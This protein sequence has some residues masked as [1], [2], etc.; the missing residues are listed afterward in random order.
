MRFTVLP[1]SVLALALAACG[2]AEEPTA[3]ETVAATPTP[4]PLPTEIPADYHG[5]WG[6]STAVCEAGRAAEG[7]LEVTGTEL[8]FYESVG[9]L[10]SVTGA[11]GGRFHGAFA[12]TGEGMNWKNE[13]V[14]DLRNNGQ[15]L[16]RREFGEQ[17]LERPVSYARCS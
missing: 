7:L 11:T 10:E 1:V 8:K 17:E 4:T 15:V 12:F 6:T 3:E 16:V 9:T 2:G 13:V 5:R 14:L